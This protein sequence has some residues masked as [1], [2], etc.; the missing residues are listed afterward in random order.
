MPNWVY[1]TLE[2]S[3]SEADLK[4]L[5]ERLEGTG[6]DSEVHPLTFMKVIPR[7]PE[8][9]G[10]WYNWNTT[11]WGTK[12][13]AVDPELSE[14]PGQITYR[15]RTAWAPPMPVVEQIVK[16]NPALDVNYFYE[17]EQGWGGSIVVS[18]G[19][20]ISHE[21]Y[22]VP[23]SHHEMVSR[24]NDCWCTAS[25]PVFPDCF[26]AM[27]D[28]RAPD[29]DPTARENAKALGKDWHGTFEELIEAAEKI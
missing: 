6:D 16:D 21:Q 20:L 8:E 7:P 2:F 26:A 14:E 15:F 29:I 23:Q 11:N 27:V 25:E 17:E 5:A 9:E 4:K 22:D 28:E 19:S 3:G 24:G 10:D 18:K 1:S 12:W 13:D